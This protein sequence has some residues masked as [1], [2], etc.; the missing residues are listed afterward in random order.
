M[1]RHVRGREPHLVAV[2]DFRR[3]GGQV[4]ANPTGKTGPL[5]LG[6]TAQPDPL[7][8]SWIS[9]GVAPSRAR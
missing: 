2:L 4:I 3:G 8:P 5:I 9:M 6:K 1:N 7:D